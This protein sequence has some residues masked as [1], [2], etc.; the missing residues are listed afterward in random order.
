MLHSKYLYTCAKYVKSF[1]CLD[2]C[3]PFWLLGT[4][5]QSGW[6]LGGSKTVG[7]ED[8]IEKHWLRC[9]SMPLTEMQ[10]NALS[11]FSFVDVSEHGDDESARRFC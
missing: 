1:V 5:R 2:Q 11:G 4:H 9:F 10:S 6:E 7:P 8:R 3:F